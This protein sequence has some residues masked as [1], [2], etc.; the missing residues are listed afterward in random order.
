MGLIESLV[1]FPD[2]MGLPEFFATHTAV[3]IDG[4]NVRIAFGVRR[5][6]EVHWLHCIVM[7][8]NRLLLA[9]HDWTT[10]AADAFSFAQMNERAI[11]GH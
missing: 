3:E 2:T 7:P 11:I 1:G 4:T 5:G 10:A 6:G 8:A 9:S